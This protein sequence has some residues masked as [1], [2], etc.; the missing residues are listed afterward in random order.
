MDDLDTPSDVIDTPKVEE[1]R[2]PG[3]QVIVLVSLKND[4]EKASRVAIIMFETTLRHAIRVLEV[5]Q[6]KT[7]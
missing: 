1:V 3:I 7:M 4:R 6:V 2:K 5:V